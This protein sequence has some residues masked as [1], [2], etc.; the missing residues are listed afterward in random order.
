LTDVD[1]I[2]SGRWQ[3]AIDLPGLGA[4]LLADMTF[5]AAPAFEAWLLAEQRR[6]AANTE[7]IL[8]EA[9]LGLMST[10]EVDRAIGLAARVTEMNPLDENH[11][12]LLIRL[13]RLAGDND[14]AARQFAACTEILDREFGVRPGPAVVQALQQTRQRRPSPAVREVASPV[15]VR[16]LIEAGSA[17]VAAGAVQAGVDSLRTAT[18]QADDAEAV[19]LRVAA[20]IALAEALIHSLRGFDEEGLA[21]LYEADSIAL[22]QGLDSALAQIRAEIGYVDFLRARYDRAEVRLTEALGFADVS[23]AERAKLTTYLGCVESDRANY[24]R[25]GDL[26]SDAVELSRAAGDPRREAYALSM[27]GRMNLFAGD[28]DAAAAF[29]DDS[30]ALAERQHWLAFLPWPQ[31]LRGEVQLARRDIASATSHFEQAFARACQ[32]GDPCWEGIAAR[33]LALVADAAGASDQAFAL[34]SDAHD[35]ANR[36]ADPY[37]WLDGYILDAKCILGRRH[38]HPDTTTWIAELRELASRT[39]MREFTLR[40]LLHGAATGHSADA[41]AAELLAGDLVDG[42]LDRL[43]RR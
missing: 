22:D 33:G 24:P 5:A 7:S 14:R 20:R 12:A 35:R 28:L 39:G 27:L 1:I 8:H 3:D 6:M 25:A 13:Y 42:T 40:S 36:H 18:R 41:A 4:E 9:A 11:H 17:A 30:T 29:L 10:G 43:I 23:A 16:A 21:A 15:A 37:V 32:L 31:A 19:P 2:Q 38:G 26:L 34:L